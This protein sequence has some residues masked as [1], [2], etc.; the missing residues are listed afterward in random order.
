M[1][2]S[3][4]TVSSVFL[5]RLSL[6]VLA[7]ALALLAAGPPAA[8]AATPSSGSVSPSAP[9]ATY[10]GGDFDGTNQ[11]GLTPID[12]APGVTPVCS[13]PLLPCDDYT[14]T[15]TVPTDPHSYAI[16]VTVTVTN[17]GA[18]FDLYLMDADG[19]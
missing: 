14:L 1:N 11:T 15:V 8:K 9:S 7:G 6:V 5:S 4:R 12:P 10:S 3:I 16:V 13:S 19:T 18:D 17:P 2:R